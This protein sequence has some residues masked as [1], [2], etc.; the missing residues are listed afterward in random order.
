MIVL[1][2]FLLVESTSFEA[3][4]SALGAAG[5]ETSIEVGTGSISAAAAV[6]SRGVMVVEVV[7]GA[8]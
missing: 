2:A 1:I 3:S 5:A 4:D 8:G 6:S 7:S